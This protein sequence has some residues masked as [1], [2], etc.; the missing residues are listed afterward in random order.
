MQRLRR[1]FRDKKV[2]VEIASAFGD[3]SDNNSIPPGAPANFKA[4]DWMCNCGMHNFASRNECKQCAAPKRGE[5]EEGEGE[6]GDSTNNGAEE[7]EGMFRGLDGDE[8]AG[9]RGGAEG[10][11][12]EEWSDGDSDSGSDADEDGS[13]SDNGNSNSSGEKKGGKKGEEKA[14]AGAE[15]EGDDSMFEEETSTVSVFKAKT[16][17]EEVVPTSEADDL[18]QQMLQKALG[19]DITSKP[20]SSSTS[21]GTIT[22]DKDGTLS[23][24]TTTTTTT[25]TG[26]DGIHGN[27]DKIDI[28]AHTLANNE[29]SERKRKM[30][31][32]VLALDPLKNPDT[33]E[34]EEAPPERVV[35]LPLCTLFTCGLMLMLLLT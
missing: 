23:T 12:G 22:V 30:L 6:K 3:N 27:T 9:E 32:A 21:T 8:A 28:S 26:F 7:N 33:I 1:R 34:G 4:G 15:D 24:T 18:R 25:T 2:T 13:D 11:D 14:E 5:G 17:A 16:G 29:S 20:T 10:E 31:P 19:F 35:V